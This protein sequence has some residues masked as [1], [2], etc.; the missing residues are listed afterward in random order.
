MEPT[1]RPLALHQY[2]ITRGD[3]EWEELVD[4]ILDIMLRTKNLIDDQPE[5][6]E[7]DIRMMGPTGNYIYCINPRQFPND[8]FSNRIARITRLIIE[9]FEKKW[10]D[11]EV[12]IIEVRYLQEDFFAS[13]SRYQKLQDKYRS[14][15]KEEITEDEKRDL[16]NLMQSDDSQLIGDIRNTIKM[17]RT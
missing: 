10:L 6:W 13:L 3:D 15:I 17:F 1:I 12:T 11:A 7:V 5:Q 4:D 16:A 8:N 9:I 14:L 2:I